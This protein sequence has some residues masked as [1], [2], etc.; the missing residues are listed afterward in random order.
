MPSLL[1]HD[2]CHGRSSSRW[3]PA[4]IEFQLSYTRSGKMM[5]WKVLHSICNMHSICNKPAPGRSPGTTRMYRISH[6]LCPCS[7]PFC[8]TFTLG[9]AGVRN[10]TQM[11]TGSAS[12]LPHLAPLPWGLAGACRKLLGAQAL[13]NLSVRP[14]TCHGATWQGWKRRWTVCLPSL[15]SGR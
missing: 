9:S 12:S 1:P 11:S 15:H 8:P 6:W 13:I 10:F 2:L 14:L 5:L 4:V 3:L 7:H